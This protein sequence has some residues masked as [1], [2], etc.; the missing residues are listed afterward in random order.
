M[1]QEN[2]FNLKNNYIIKYKPNLYWVLFT[3]FNM[4][5]T[6]YHNIHLNNLFDLEQCYNIWYCDELVSSLIEK[7]D[8]LKPIIKY[9]LFGQ[10][11]IF[12]LEYF[13]QINKIMKLNLT[14]TMGLIYL[15]ITISIN[16]FF[17]SYNYDKY[18]YKAYNEYMENSDFFDSIRFIT[19]YYISIELLLYGIII[20]PVIFFHWMFLKYLINGNKNKKN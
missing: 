3:I 7:T 13:F 18:F 20:L 16:N 8:T 2:Q 10:I 12:T 17:Y 4:F 15:I 1:I 11:S 5:A 9:F 19:Y 6:T 14:N